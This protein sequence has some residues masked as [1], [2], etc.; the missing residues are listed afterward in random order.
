MSSDID[1]F[2]D[3]CKAVQRK[4]LIELEEV[5]ESLERDE[6]QMNKHEVINK[7]ADE[8]LESCHFLTYEQEEIIN[9]THNG[10]YDEGYERYIR[11]VEIEDND[12][13]EMQRLLA[14]AALYN[15]MKDVLQEIFEC[16]E[17]L[18]EAMK[19]LD[20]AIYS[21]GVEAVYEY[22][23]V[24]ETVHEFRLEHIVENEWRMFD[25]NGDVF[26]VISPDVYIADNERVIPVKS[27]NIWLDNICARR[28]NELKNEQ[29][30]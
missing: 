28:I 14:T 24:Q 12:P 30:T 2:S 8:S 7:T 4:A 27:L 17:S 10:Y 20:D 26:E 1:S 18:G 9:Y 22:E 15:D 25:P 3:Y 5:E 13:L 23:D 6:I 21:E 16:R 11:D 19:L 29:S